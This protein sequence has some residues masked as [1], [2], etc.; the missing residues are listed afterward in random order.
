MKKRIVGIASLCGLF[1]FY[2][3][4]RYSLFGWHGMVSF[5]GYLLVVG[6]IAVGISGI[7]IGRKII[8]VFTAAGYLAGFFIGH[9]FEADIFDP[10]SGTYNSNM[11]MIWTVTFLSAI[12]AGVFAETFCE[13]YQKKHKTT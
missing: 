9:I 5:P 3:V 8:P 1:I 11:W 12:F 7:I 4:C 2:Y 6:I 10:N 13:I